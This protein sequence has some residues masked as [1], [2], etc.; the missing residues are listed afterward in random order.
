MKRLAL[1]FL[2]SV[3][4][5]SCWPSKV[6]FID[7]GSM[8]EEWKTFSVKTLENT[9]P[10][11]PISYA[12]QLSEQLKDGIQN[13]TRLL[14]NPETGKG[15]IYIEGKITGYSVLP[16]AIQEGD[17]SAKNRLSI[18]AQFT[19][20]VSKPKEDKMI[21]SSTR[22]VDYDSNTDLGTVERTLLEEISTQIV[23]DVINKLLSNW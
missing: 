8:P 7:N 21:V 2:L 1:F 23:Q 13:N 4:L 20:F 19:I 6:S 17:N 18:S 5:S 11:T 10:N 14:L 16:V 15:E 9:A 3:L 12:A 22:F